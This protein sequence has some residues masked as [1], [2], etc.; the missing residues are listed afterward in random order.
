RACLENLQPGKALLPQLSAQL[1]RMTGVEVKPEDWNPQAIDRHFHMRYAVEREGEV[2]AT[3]RSLAELQAQ[4]GGE[5]SEQFRARADDA[6]LA[7]SGLMDW[8]FDILPERTRLHGG[9]GITS[10]PALVDYADSVAIE[11]FE[12]QQEADFYHPSGV[13][14]L[15]MFRLRDTVRYAVRNLPGID[16]SALAYASIGSK[17][18]LVDDL[19]MAT[20]IDAIGK[21]A[22]REKEDFD[23]RLEA[24][25]PQFLSL[26][27]ERAEILG[28]TL[29][30]WRKAR[31]VLEEAQLPGPQ[32]ED[33]GEQMDYLIYEGFLRATP[34]DALARLPAY[35]QAI[36]KRIEK[37]PN[38][39]DDRSLPVLR[40]LWQ[41]WLEF[42][43]D[44]QGDAQQR[45]RIRWMIEEWRINLFAQPMKTRFPVSEKKIR[46][47]LAELGG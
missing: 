10:F 11:L 15:M 2:L 20:L 32:R 6:S 36:V 38:A 4:L 8:D 3:G 29:E 40:E 14:R 30:A 13:A 28:K 47:A 25:R 33:I 46:V 26:A 22:P 19:L 12:S 44:Q 34:A 24:L 43:S 18:D 31:S 42:E 7:R 27:N 1:R 39:Q 35:F 23:H 45:E 16:R 5:A 9:G 41:Q 37:F 21:P 17:A